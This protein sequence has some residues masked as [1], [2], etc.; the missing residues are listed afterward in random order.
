MAERRFLNAGLALASTVGLLELSSHLLNELALDG[1]YRHL[2]V[3]TEWNAWSW[4]GSA[5]IFGA[6][7]A[8]YVCAFTFRRRPRLLGLLAVWFA[9][10][11]LD[12][13]VEVH[14]RLGIRLGNATGLAG[15]EEAGRLWVIV[16]LPALVASLVA[17]VIIARELLEPRVRN[18]LHGG[19]LLL[20]GAVAA[21]IVGA[22]TRRLGDSFT[23]VHVVDVAV[24]EAAETTGWMLLAVALFAGA[25]GAAGAGGSSPHRPR[26]SA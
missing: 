14:E 6:A 19:L 17:L 11:S 22:G 2:D 26:G 23:W 16:Y 3:D 5:A 25:L 24:E 10:L 20:A 21:E 8:A 18:L 13:V 15:G 1:R 12:D 9:F 7:T 4:A